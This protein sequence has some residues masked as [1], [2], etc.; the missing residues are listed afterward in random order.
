M[1]KQSAGILLYRIRDKRLQLFLIHPGGPFFRNK[2]DGVWSI[3]KGEFEDGEEALAAAKREFEEETGQS[4][5]GK[6]IPLDPITQKGGKKVFCWAVEG[7]ID[8]ETITSNIFEIEW[9]LRSGRKQTFPEVDRAG[10]FE[11]EA[12]KTKINE[13]QIGLIEELINKLSL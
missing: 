7:D 3:P 9:P 11:V 4:I 6:F 1:P 8:H 2:D 13:A 10:W 12:A 5:S